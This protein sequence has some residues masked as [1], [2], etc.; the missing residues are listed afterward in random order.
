MQWPMAQNLAYRIVTK[1]ERVSRTENKSV[2]CIQVAGYLPLVSPDYST[3]KKAFCEFNV[4]HEWLWRIPEVS[5]K[6]SWIRK[7][8]ADWHVFS[9]GRLCFEYDARWRQELSAIAKC[10]T[11]GQTA[12]FAV[13]WL[14]NSTRSLLNRHLFA[15]RNDLVIWSKQWDFWAHGRGEAERQLIREGETGH[16]RI[17]A[18]TGKR[19]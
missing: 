18:T 11:F 17:G 5:C 8:V 3:K 14:L 4:N 12:D 6:E 10:Y 13:E 9:D 7:G 19:Y 16:E 2:K 15:S 1:L